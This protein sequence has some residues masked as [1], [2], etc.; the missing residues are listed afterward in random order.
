MDYK[1]IITPRKLC[2]AGMEALAAQANYEVVDKVNACNFLP[3]LQKV[4]ALMIKEGGIG[5][6]DMLACPDLKVI[7]RHGVGFDTVDAKAAAELGIPVVITP[8]ANA[9]SVAE[10]TVAMI[11]ALTKNLVTCHN[12]TIKG[13]WN[14]RQEFRAYE[15][16]G[17]TVGLIGVGNIGRIVHR[18]AWDLAFTSRPTILSCRKKSWLRQ[19]T[20]P[21]GR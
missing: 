13:N 8:G 6:E 16:E 3:E 20:V 18:C 5:R 11:L 9:R 19:A 2:D 17:K 4:D 1:V 10:H 14:I 21:A 7:A 15:F 12:E